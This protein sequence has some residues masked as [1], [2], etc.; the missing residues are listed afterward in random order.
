M[1]G[2]TAN[3][4]GSTA[5]RV[6]NT[7]G[8][9]TNT[10]GSAS[11]AGSGTTGEL[12]STGHG[13]VGMPGVTLSQASSATSTVTQGTTISSTGKNVRLDSGTQMVLSVGGTVSNQ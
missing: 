12:T 2:G 7:V 6:G 10:G 13:V 5:G 11:H 9:T 8:S 1:V 4:V 3:T